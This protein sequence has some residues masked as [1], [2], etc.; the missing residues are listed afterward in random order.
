MR[1]ADRSG[2]ATRVGMASFEAT[3]GRGNWEPRLEA[4][5]LHDLAMQARGA[6]CRLRRATAILGLDRDGGAT[7]RFHRP[8]QPFDGFID[9]LVLMLGIGDRLFPECIRLMQARRSAIHAALPIRRFRPDRILDD[10]GA[11]VVNIG[12]GEHRKWSALA[13]IGLG[14]QLGRECESSTPFP[15]RSWRDARSSAPPSPCPAG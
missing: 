14:A 6:D 11:G 7:A 12:Q 10:R 5:S 13:S 4:H 2:H 3:R 9:P 1:E 15:P 8:L